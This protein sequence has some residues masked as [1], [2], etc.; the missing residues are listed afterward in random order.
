MVRRAILR[1][2][3]C[4]A[5]SLA[6]AMSIMVSAASAQDKWPSR[7]VTIV[8]PF[9][10]GSNTDA[11]ARLVADLLR[12][13]YG[14]PFIVENRG[15]AGGTLGANAVAKSAP[16]GYTLLMAGNTSLPPRRRCSRM[17]PTIQSRNSPRSRARAGFRP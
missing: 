6:F 9:A 3:I 12:D 13:L 8:V 1:V 2:G 4:A 17:C 10:A 7:R 16:D 15:G 14:Q 11:F 5:L